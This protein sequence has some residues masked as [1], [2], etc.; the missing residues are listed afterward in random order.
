MSSGIKIE[1]HHDR[2]IL[3]IDFSG[4]K[5]DEMIKMLVEF[6][7]IIISGNK[8]VLVLGIFSNKNFLTTRF[9]QAFRKVKR[10]ESTPFIAKQAVIGLD[11]NKRIIV[12]GFNAFFKR[13]IQSFDTKDR[14]IQYLI[15]E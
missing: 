5:E 6:R 15:S 1:I 12:K 7:D 4:Y 10:V 11:E 3:I 14:A 13:D 8:P 2:E 9:M